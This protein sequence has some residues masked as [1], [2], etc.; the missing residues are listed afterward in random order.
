MNFQDSLKELLKHE[1]GYVNHPSDPGGET[2]Y[3]VTKRV[4]L[5]FG[6]TG[7][8]QSIPMPLVEKIY[9]QG[10]W[11]A[12]QADKLPDALRHHVFD[13]AVNSGP[14]QALKWLQEAIKVTA[15][16]V[17]GP[18]TLKAVLEANPDLVARRYCAIRLRFL[19]GLKTWPVFGAGWTR[20]VC[21]YLEKA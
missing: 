2:N 1:G 3:G 12:I 17:L 11:D 21:D 10:Y 14:V 9:R 18:M 19:T 15:D 4:A 6:Y 5:S 16:G 7:D 20:R 8:M 13:A